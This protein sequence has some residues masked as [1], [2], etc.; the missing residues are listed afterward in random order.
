MSS[1]IKGEYDSFKTN[2]LKTKCSLK[3]SIFS[4]ILK[5]KKKFKTLTLYKKYKVIIKNN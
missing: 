5:K 3:G 2:P 4:S 1:C